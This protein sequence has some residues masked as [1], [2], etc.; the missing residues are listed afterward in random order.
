M[1]R[2]DV[3]QALDQRIDPVSQASEYQQLLLG[4]A[5]GRDPAQIQAEQ[6]DQMAE[7]IDRAGVRLRTRPA[8][9]EWSVLECAGH[10]LDAEIVSSARYRWIVAHDAPALIGY[11]QDL[12]VSRLAHQ[13]DDPAEVIALFGALRRANLEMWARIPEDQRAR[14]GIHAERGPESYDLTFR[15]VAGHGILHLAQADRTLQSVS[16]D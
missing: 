15:L 7:L 16:S 8:P 10:M 3:E 6:P 2:N 1:E 5:S 9:Q 14:V 12:W 4:L 11:D 13:D